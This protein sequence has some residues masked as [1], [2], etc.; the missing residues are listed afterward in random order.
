MGLN[1]GDIEKIDDNLTRLDCYERIYNWFTKTGI[2]ILENEIISSKKN[3]QDPGQE[4][5]NV[6][7]L[8]FNCELLKHLPSPKNISNMELDYITIQ[9]IY[10]K[11]EWAFHKEDDFNIK[12]AAYAIRMGKIKDPINGWQSISVKDFEQTPLY[13]SFGIH[14]EKME[15]YFKEKQKQ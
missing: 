10:G 1:Q 6:K 4:D 15:E 12:I 8:I 9:C 11:L 14:Q 2:S 5:V 3:L 7:G 13:I